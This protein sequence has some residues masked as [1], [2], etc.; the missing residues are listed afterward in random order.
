MSEYVADH[1]AIP[2]HPFRTLLAYNLPYWRRYALGSILSLAYMLLTLV[3]PLIVKGAVAE[4]KGHLGTG[5]SPDAAQALHALWIYFGLL[6][7]ASLVTGIL[8]YG[9]RML[10]IGA[11][12]QFEYD[13]RNDYFR[14]IQRLSRAFFTSTKTGDIMARATNDLNY[15]RMFIGPGIMGTIDMLRLPFTLALMIWLSPMLTLVVLLPMPL[16]SFAVYKIVMFTHYK[17]KEVQA[18][19]STLTARAQENL[20]GARVVKAYGI[21]EREVAA[22]HTIADK[23]RKESLTLSIVESMIWPVIGILVGVTIMIVLWF[24]GRMVIAGNLPFE[25]FSAFI[26]CIFLLVFPLAQFGWILTLYQRGAAG[27]NRITDIM[28]REPDIRDTARTDESIS[29]LTGSV[30]FDDVSFG[31]DEAPVLQGITFSL[32]AGKTLAIVGATGS[33]KSSLVSLLTREYDPRSGTITVD[34]HD[35]RDIPVDTIRRAIGY[36]PQDTFLFSDTIANNLTLG[37]PNADETA[38]RRAADIAQFSETV[39]GFE[40]K[41][42]TL[43]GERGV[44]LSGGQK[45]RLT[46]ARALIRDPQILIL[47]D[48]LSSVD[49]HT[50]EDILE[51]LRTVTQGRTTI[52]IAHRISAVRHADEILV[53]DEGRIV[54]RGV[55]GDL[56]QGGGV[57][58]AMYERQLLE[59]ELEER[60]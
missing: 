33:G 18:I 44:N 15:V 28:A 45:Q 9:Q 13:I 1:R 4:L 58:A 49:A 32:S 55:H 27:M 36:V 52:I 21:T 23:Y 41:W 39:E 12:R 51:G 29:E 19:F 47:D 54:E 3:F 6:T 5:D 57:Y 20:A 16:V 50:E 14:H 37:A 59:D 48:A 31:Y 22:F 8:R 10:M 17:S 38:L 43:L 11:S 35:L 25:N 24:G 2:G 40:K 46:I 60:S 26:F 53:L 7:G 30:R 34:G 56:I 42:D